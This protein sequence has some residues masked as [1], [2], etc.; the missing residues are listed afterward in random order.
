MSDYCFG[1]N[2]CGK[3]FIIREAT[4]IKCIGGDRKHDELISMRFVLRSCQ[5]VFK[6]HFVTFD[7]KLII[8]K[9]DGTK[10]K[11][12]DELQ[13]SA[14]IVVNLIICV[15]YYS[16]DPVVNFGKKLRLRTT[17][18]TMQKYPLE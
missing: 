15:H 18:I 4:I 8:K 12:R 14:A 17:R 6:Y 9:T 7:S 11:T 10:K 3:H 13:L 16:I 5:R 1:M 2:N